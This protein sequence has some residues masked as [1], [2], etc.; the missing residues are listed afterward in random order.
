MTPLQEEYS[1]HRLVLWVEDAETRAYL[2]ALFEDRELRI[3]VGGGRD[4]V[5][6]MVEDAYRSRHR[7]VF[8][9]VDRD[10]GDSNRRRWAGLDTRVFTLTRHEVENYLLD[11]V[12]LAALPAQLCHRRSA[13]EVDARL[14]KAA[15]SQTWYMATRAFIQH[16]STQVGAIPKHPKPSDVRL[17]NHAADWIRSQLTDLAW[18]ERARCGVDFLQSAREPEGSLMALESNFR[19]MT[20]DDQWRTEFSGKEILGS[21]NVGGWLRKNRVSVED[22]VGAIGRTQ[23]STGSVPEDLTALHQILRQRAGLPTP[24]PAPAAT[25]A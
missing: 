16:F 12:V 20:A 22:L 15:R 19:A 11:P 14:Q 21:E 3:L 24:P 5:A 7:N 2:S 4:H 10:F 18:Q 6:A 9:V 8:G 13:D 17:P 23:R 25:P 1:R